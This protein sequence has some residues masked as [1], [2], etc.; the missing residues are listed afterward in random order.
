MF[1][2]FFISYPFLNCSGSFQSGFTCIHQPL[3]PNNTPIYI[4]YTYY[5]N[6]DHIGN[7]IGCY[8][9]KTPDECKLMCDQNPL[10]KGFNLWTPLSRKGCCLKNTINKIVP[11]F[12]ADLYVKK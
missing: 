10:C 5:N 8:E 9:Q 6:L 1:N 4:N 7:D 3:N 2:S 11:N 12:T